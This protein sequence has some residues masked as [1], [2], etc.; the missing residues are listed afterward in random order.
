MFLTQLTPRRRQGLGVC[1]VA[2]RGQQLHKPVWLSAPPEKV[3][4]SHE[5]L[6]LKQIKSISV[7]KLSLAH[8]NSQHLHLLQSSSSTL[9]SVRPEGHLD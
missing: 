4:Y 9:Q 1:G 8:V 3:V 5:D 6:V 2:D 7:R